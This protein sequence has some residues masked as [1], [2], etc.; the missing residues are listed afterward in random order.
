MAA[1]RIEY[2]DDLKGFALIGVVWF[3][4]SH[5]AFWDFSF[6]IPLFFFVSGMFFRPYPIKKFLSKKINQ[7]VIP[8]LFFYLIYFVYLM[9][10]WVS[11]GRSFDTFNFKQVLGPFQLHSG[12]EGFSINP[13]LWFIFSLIDM[14]VLLYLFTKITSNKFIV[15]LFGLAISI[16]GALYFYHVPTPLMFSRS[17]PYMIYFVLGYIS[18]PYFIKILQDKTHRAR[19]LSRILLISSSTIFCTCIGLIYFK[20]M[21]NANQFGV[22]DY[23]AI[24][25]TIVLLTYLV[26]WLYRFKF[27]KLFHFFGENT[28]V[29]LGIHDMVLTILLI[30]VEH[31]GWQPNQILGIIMVCITLGVAYPLTLFFNKY[32][33]SL[34]GKKDLVKIKYI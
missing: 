33:P 21:K 26:K 27:M 14:Q 15:L 24:L 22:L 7:L 2:I 10:M 6:R 29:L 12:S 31:L 16:F 17:T 20:G 19:V 25:S 3:H 34:V 4:T 18:A 5:P 23:L 9:C 28:F 1:K 32:L 30:S 11:S 8:T 13:P